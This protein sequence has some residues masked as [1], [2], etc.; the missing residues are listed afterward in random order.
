MT[1][2]Q[3]SARPLLSHT[4]LQGKERGRAWDSQTSLKIKSTPSHCSGLEWIT[5]LLW[6]SLYLNYI[7]KQKRKSKQLRRQ[8]WE[9]SGG[10]GCQSPGS[11]QG[12]LRQVTG[13]ISDGQV[14]APWRGSRTQRRGIN[15]AE[16]GMLGTTPHSPTQ[17]RRSTSAYNPAIMKNRHHSR[18]ASYS[19]N[20][21]AR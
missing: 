13:M 9:Q 11:Q 7:L 20:L 12:G 8:Y 17:L 14:L 19:G 21:P 10:T 1:A 18:W 6:D 2:P 3:L 15:T 16:S 4:C 5:D